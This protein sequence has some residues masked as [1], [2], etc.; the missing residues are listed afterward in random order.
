MLGLLASLALAEPLAVPADDEPVS[1]TALLWQGF[2]HRWLRRVLGAWAVPHR[3]SLFDSHLEEDEDGATWHFAQSTGVDGDHMRPVGFYS[4]VSAP[5]VAFTR[6]TERFSVTDDAGTSPV[7]KAFHRF[8]RLLRVQ[9]SEDEHAVAVI[10]GL[11]FHSHC[12]AGPGACNSNGIWPYRFLVQL[13]PCE[14]VGSEVICPVI[15]EVGRAWTPNRGGVKGIEEKP[16]DR[17]M[18]LDID[19]HWT[20]LAGPH[21]ALAS[22]QFLFENALPSSHRIIAEEQVLP[23]PVQGGGRYPTATVALSSFGFEFFPTGLRRGLAHRGRYIGAWGMNVHP[24]QYDEDAGL[25][26]VGHSGDIWLPTTVTRTGLRLELGITALQ[27]GHPDATVVEGTPV[28]GSLCADSS[29]NAP[30]FSRWERC[31]ELA[32]GERTEQTV[33]FTAPGG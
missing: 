26:L 11:T 21:E 14:P 2:D 6:G 25:L 4:E 18:S 19:V 23:V 20:M 33:R 3:V 28:E 24:R 27:L 1:H 10:R 32:D 22:E 13:S 5:D 9:A 31:A 8:H 12:E 17:R 29:D 16:I 15:V 7:P 30:G